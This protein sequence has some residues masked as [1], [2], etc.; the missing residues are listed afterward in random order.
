MYRHQI[1]QNVL[2][3]CTVEH[4]PSLLSA[5]ESF[6]L[7]WEEMRDVGY[8]LFNYVWLYRTT[9]IAACTPGHLS[10]AILGIYAALCAQ[11]ALLKVHWVH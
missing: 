8:S 5:L 7:G 3:M 11:M 2:S 6:D 1:L 10:G 9:A 4:L